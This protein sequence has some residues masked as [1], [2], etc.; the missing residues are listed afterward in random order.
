MERKVGSI[1]RRTAKGLQKEREREKAE[2]E[3]GGE[4]I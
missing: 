2:R 3:R 1:R 4:G